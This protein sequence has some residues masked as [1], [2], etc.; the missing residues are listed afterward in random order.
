[1]TSAALQKAAAQ[2]RAV[3]LASTILEIGA[4]RPLRD[5]AAELTRLGVHTERGGR[6]HPAGV[7]RVLRRIGVIPGIEIGVSPIRILPPKS[8]SAVVTSPP[9]ANQRLR[10]YGGISESDYPAWTVAWMEKV[11]PILVDGGNVAVVIRPH[12]KGG[13]ISDYVLRTRLAIRAAGWQEIEELIWVKPSAA[14]LGHRYR[15]RRSWESILW[16]SNS[17][18]PYCDPKA[19]GRSSDRIGYATK[20]GLQDY[21][22]STNCKPPASGIA[23]CR[24]YVEVATA[25]ANRDSFNHHPAQYPTKLAEWIIKL[26]CPPGGV[27]IDPFMG[28]GTTAVAARN[29]GRRFVGCDISPAFVSIARRRLVR[30]RRQ[31]RQ[32]DPPVHDGSPSADGNAS[33]GPQ[34]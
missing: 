4:A 9:Y 14:P 24:D 34:G 6:W 15:P 25:A 19:N 20:K 30:R 11:R 12:V 22:H 18:R 2:R 1:M 23:R 10:Q 31:G 13:Q 26:L 5:I 3:A 17:P 32:D 33:S 7:E 8:I 28:S 27:V 21:V 16:F 29:T